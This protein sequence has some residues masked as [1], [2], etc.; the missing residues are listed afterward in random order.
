MKKTIEKLWEGQ[1]N[2]VELF[3]KNNSRV[4]EC[5]AELLERIEK[6]EKDIGES[7]TEHLLKIANDC[8][9]IVSKNAFCDGFSLGLKMAVEAMMN[10]ENMHSN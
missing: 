4:R 2:P 5:E 3:G 8:L 10:A 6:L 7:K 1:V 9:E